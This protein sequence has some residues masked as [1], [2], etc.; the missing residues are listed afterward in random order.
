MRG[1][2]SAALVLLVFLS[3]VAIGRASSAAERAPVATWSVAGELARS[4]A[5]ARAIALETGEI[6]VVGGLDA[7]DDRVTIPTT[8]LFDPRTGRSTVLPQRLLGRLNQQLT[9]AWGGRVVVTGGTEWIDGHWNSVAKVDVYLPWPR[10]W[11]SAAHMLQPRSDHAATALLDG[12]VFVTGGNYNARLLRSSEIYDVERDLWTPVAPMPRARTQFSAATLPDGSVLVA[13]GFEPDGRMVTTTFIYEP[14]ADRWVA[15]PEM[16]EVRLNH[17]M[18]RLPGG[19]VLFFGGERMGAETAER[20]SWR[21]R[22]FVHAGV[23]AE[24]RLVAQG[25]LLPDGRVVAVGGLPIDRDRTRFIPT[26]RAEMWDPAK[27]VW[28]VLPG[29][30]TKRAYA[31]LIVTDHGVFRLSGV[32]ID[33]DPYSTIEALVWR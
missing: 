19:D 5:Y 6:L 26:E 9:T 14:W 29:A 16:R 13:G 28:Q 27:R 15:G 17:S 10:Q 3:G 31:Q 33:E 18:V 22:R 25:A 12:R 30:P 21:E 20:Y 8:E 11:L 4:R 32:G 1:L 2:A 7:K 23:L 24:P